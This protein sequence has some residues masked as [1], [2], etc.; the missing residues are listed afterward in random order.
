[1]AEKPVHPVTVIRAGHI[2]PVR[3]A[4][5]VLEEFAVAIENSTIVAIR[6]SD[7]LKRAYPAATVIDLPHH[8][9]LPGLINMHTHSP[10]TLLRGYADDQSLQTWL[11]DHIWP[12]EQHFV[13]PEFVSDGTRLAVAE[14]IRAGTTCFNDMYFHPNQIAQVCKEA[15]IRASI[16][17][18]LIELE[19][20]SMRDVERHFAQAEEIYQEWSGEP[21]L[22]FSF[23]PHAPYTVS[24]ETL[25]KVG[26]MSRSL[27]V[28]V[29]MHLLETT[30]DIKHSLQHHEVSPLGRLKA[31]GLLNSRLQAVH[32]TQLSEEDIRLLAANSVNVVHCPQS[33]LKLASG[34]CPVSELIDAGVNVSVGTDGAASNNDLDILAE[35][36]T[37]ALLAKGVS[38]DAETVSAFQALEM[39]T[40]NGARA[41]GMESQLG[42]I[43]CGKQAD[44]CA[45][46]LSGPET[47]PLHHV[48]SQLVY[49]AS[50]RQVSDVWV[51][52][53]RVL[54]SRALTAL[55]L[56]KTI[57]KA[58]YW[59]KRL[60]EFSQGKQT[61]ERLS[62]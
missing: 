7:E 55:D 6:P 16:G 36:Q 62:H 25:A 33:N 31:L 39:I 57:T 19:T 24:D 26:K 30:W 1:M 58:K 9:L 38:G 4:G 20:F 45:I 3:P 43:E 22:Q 12:A 51:A 28:P 23:A 29:H 46:D 8:A 17:V 53:K 18:P 14:M 15:G 42:S 44:L 11:G 60:A 32:M 52:G 40:I 54:E 21:L 56:E 2:V 37:A 5:V 34:I 10:M 48:V 13:G 35:A 49:A 59:K 27:D 47:Q 41:L 61:Q 50:A